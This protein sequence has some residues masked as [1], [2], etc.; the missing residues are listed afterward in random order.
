MLQDFL[1]LVFGQKLFVIQSLAV[2]DIVILDD[3]INYI[4]LVLLDPSAE[5]LSLTNRPLEVVILHSLVQE[6]VLVHL[7]GIGHGIHEVG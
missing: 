1:L 4:T 6:W 2:R 7:V 5:P 3:G